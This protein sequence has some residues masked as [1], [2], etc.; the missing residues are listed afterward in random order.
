M[1]YVATELSLV[2]Q[3]D[4]NRLPVP[5]RI[6]NDSIPETPETFGLNLFQVAESPN[7]ELSGNRADVTVTDDDGMFHFSPEFL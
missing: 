2:F 4:V 6:L 3:P 5:I 7:L 1:D